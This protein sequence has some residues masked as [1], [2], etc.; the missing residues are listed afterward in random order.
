MDKFPLLKEG[1]PSGELI[2]EREALYTWFTARGP[3][4]EGDELW[5]AWV[6]GEGGELRL[7]ILEPSGDV[8]SIRRRFSDRMTRPLN[9]LLRGEIRPAG[10]KETENWEPAPA[11]DRLFRAPWLRQRLKGTQGA[12][13]RASENLRYLAIP[14]DKGKPF[15]LPTLFCFAHVR[16]IGEAQYVV[17]C[18]DDHENPRF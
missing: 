4:P 12:Q 13:I 1:I 14:Y 17:Y 5:C 2:A 3:L 8:G 18:F 15:P 11:P 10:A 9:R 7:G 16:P 6:I